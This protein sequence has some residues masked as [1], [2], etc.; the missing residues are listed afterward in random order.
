MANTRIISS[1]A[2]DRATLTASSTAGVLVAS[3]MQN[4]KTS[5]VYRSA[6][7]VTTITITGTMSAAESASGAALLGN[8]SPTA[9]IRVQLYDATSG[10]TMVL[11]TNTLQ[12]GALACPAPVIRL[13]GWTAAQSASAYAYGGGAIARIWF[14][15]TPF[16]RFV[17]TITDTS[18]LQGCIEV[19]RAYVGAYWEPSHN[20]STLSATDVD[21]TIFGES[22]S[23]DAIV[24]AG[25]IKR[26]VPISFE[27]LPASDRTIL[28]NMLRNSRA[29]PIFLSVFPGGAD[30]SLERDHTVIG[31]RTGNSD[32]EVQ[33]AITYGTKIEVESI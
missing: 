16:L 9:A 21:S 20:P 4:N 5:S 11:D 33:M 3:N 31:Y 14:A 17:I 7:G 12:P 23:G 29:Y 18:N 30:L 22:D 8:F 1:N 6:A 25:T 10:G 32:I 15:L 2:A 28:A 26:K 27:F 24:Q 19:P 13:E